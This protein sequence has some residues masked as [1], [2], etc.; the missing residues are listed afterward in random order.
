MAPE[1][2]SASEAIAQIHDLLG[3]IAYRAGMTFPS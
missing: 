2:S 1:I 3:K